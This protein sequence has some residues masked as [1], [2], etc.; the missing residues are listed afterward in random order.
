MA[1]SHPAE[2]A[3]SSFVSQHPGHVSALGLIP[4]ATIPLFS[5][6]FPTEQ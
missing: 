5:Y 6:L 1:P 2:S 3:S 4:V